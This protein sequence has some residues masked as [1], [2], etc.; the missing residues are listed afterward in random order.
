MAGLALTSHAR[1][2]A[3]S[4]AVRADRHTRR[5]DGIL[6][7]RGADRE[8]IY[9]PNRPAFIRGLTGSRLASRI[10]LPEVA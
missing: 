4:G 10:R 2:W 6:R 9:I 7:M 3:G 5:F 8:A 1:M